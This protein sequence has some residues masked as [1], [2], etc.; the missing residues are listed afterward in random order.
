[1]KKLRL[2]PNHNAELEQTQP[3]NP[4]LTSKLSKAIHDHSNN[5]YA[6]V[7]LSGKLLVGNPEF[8]SLINYAEHQLKGIDIVSFFTPQDRDAIVTKLLSVAS[9]QTNEIHFETRMHQQG[10]KG[11]WIQAQISALKND[12][13]SLF[14]QITNI[15]DYKQKQLK[16]SKAESEMIRFTQRVTEDLRNPLAAVTQVNSIIENELSNNNY[17]SARKFAQLSQKTIN[18]LSSL[19]LG[20]L[21]VNELKNDNEH[22]YAPIDPSAIIRECIE[23]AKHRH[24]DIGGVEILTT[25]QHTNDY[26]GNYKALMKAIE[27]LVSNAIKFKDAEKGICFVEVRSFEENDLLCIEIIDNGLGIPQRYHK[28]LFNMFCRFHPTLSDGAGLGLYLVK[29]CADEMNGNVYYQANEHEGSTFTLKI[30][31]KH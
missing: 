21:N 19:V 27:S 20:V 3:N 13:D 11:C 7:S 15:H 1:M 26:T 16:A 2:V 23:K 31:R 9:K 29:K 25:L 28:S 17:E 18:K 24:Q 8:Y 5:I 22:S 14:L 6:I 30:P 10:G 12:D 4:D